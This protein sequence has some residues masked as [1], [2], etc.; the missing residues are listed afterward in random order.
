MRLVRL[1]LPTLLVLAACDTKSKEQYK[2]LA[3]T[4]S[5]RTDS[6]VSIKNDLLNEVM[7]STQFVN[8]LNDELA[9]LK[10]RSRAKLSTKLSAESD[11]AAIKEERATLV[12]H[13]REIVARLDSSEAR[14]SSLRR[15]AA[16]LAARDT[17][18]VN[19][20]AEFEK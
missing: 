19:Q 14:V 4:D 6:L 3:H 7:T 17:T 12:Q 13:I 1:L 2:T 5:L 18:L 8:D 16:S 15:R 9:K 10:S 11:M 20:V